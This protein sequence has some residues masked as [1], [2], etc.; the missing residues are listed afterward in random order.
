M[1]KISGDSI[2]CYRHRAI[3]CRALKT[4]KWDSAHRG[5]ETVLMLYSDDRL[6]VI[7]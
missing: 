6:T 7:L 2:T 5:N 4:L 1:V 3:C